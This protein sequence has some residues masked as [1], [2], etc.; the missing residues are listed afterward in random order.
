L[1][2]RPT[3][4]KNVMLNLFIVYP[5]IKMCGE[6][7]PKITKNIEASGILFTFSLRR[8]EPLLPEVIK[9]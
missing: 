5:V 8:V 3:N 6:G 4:N 7:D 2:N 1:L 9:L